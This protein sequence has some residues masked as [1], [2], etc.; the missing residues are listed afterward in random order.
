VNG[1]AAS[2]GK[3]KGLC[4]A[5]LGNPFLHGKGSGPKLFA[6]GL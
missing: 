1:S 3:I 6:K 5:K 4:A 2:A